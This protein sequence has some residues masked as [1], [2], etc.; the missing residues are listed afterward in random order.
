MVYEG[1]ES[2]DYIA[3][4]YCDYM[5]KYSSK[6]KILFEKVTAHG[7]YKFNIIIVLASLCDAKYENSK[8]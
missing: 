4:A 3:K 5:S 8:K 1:M 6:I 7:G 2:K